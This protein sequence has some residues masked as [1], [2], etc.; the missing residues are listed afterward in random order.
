MTFRNRCANEG[1]IK[2]LALPSLRDH[3]SD[4]G[5]LTISDKNRIQVAGH[6]VELA[7]SGGAIGGYSCSGRRGR[8]DPIACSCTARPCTQGGGETEVGTELRILPPTTYAAPR[9][10][11]VVTYAQNDT[12]KR[13]R[14]PRT[15]PINPNLPLHP[16]RRAR[17]ERL[18]SESQNG[19]GQFEISRGK[20]YSV[21]LCIFFSENAENR[22]R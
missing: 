4:N 17:P 20:T 13:A 1:W 11:I 22:S 6:A 2:T 15:T 3:G 14:T 5:A 12:H 18:V 21:L 10:N 19:S 16:L 8:G 9:P 7:R